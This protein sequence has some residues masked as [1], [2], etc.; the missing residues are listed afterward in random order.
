MLNSRALARAAARAKH[1]LNEAVA[2]LRAGMAFRAE[3]RRR[4][5]VPEADENPVSRDGRGATR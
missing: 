1:A 5:P 2:D 4:R 3:E